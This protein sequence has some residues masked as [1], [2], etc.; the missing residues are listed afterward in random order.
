VIEISNVFPSI[1]KIWKGEVDKYDHFDC[2]CCGMSSLHVLYPGKKR[3]KCVACGKYCTSYMG[4]FDDE[5]KKK[6]VS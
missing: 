5:I 1:E 2:S 4:E 6:A 3:W